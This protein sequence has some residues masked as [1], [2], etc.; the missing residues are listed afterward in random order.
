MPSLL[1][2]AVA[3]ARYSFVGAVLF[4]AVAAAAVVSLLAVA[5][6]V[7]SVA[8]FVLAAVVVS[9]ALQLPVVPESG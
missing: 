2:P 5:A 4:A 1:V 9:V 3:A 8:S 7:V 6:I